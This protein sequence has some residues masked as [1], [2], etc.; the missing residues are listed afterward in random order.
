MKKGSM[1][2]AGLLLGALLP[3]ALG[4]VAGAQE[5]SGADGKPRFGKAFGELHYLGGFSPGEKNW[6]LEQNN[7]QRGPVQLITGGRILNI[8]Q[9]IHCV[10]R[11]PTDRNLF[12]S[13]SAWLGTRPDMSALTP[14]EIKYV[15]WQKVEFDVAIADCPKTWGEAV[16]AIDGPEG[17][18]NLEKLKMQEKAAQDQAYEEGVQQA[19]AARSGEPD[20]MKGATQLPPARLAALSAELDRALTDLRK[21]IPKLDDRTFPDEVDAKITPLL[22][23]IARSGMAEAKAIRKGEAG[24][25]Q[26]EAWDAGAARAVVEAVMRLRGMS[27]DVWQRS[28]QVGAIWVRYLG[29]Y[30]KQIA[31]RGFFEPQYLKEM[32]AAVERY[33]IADVPGEAPTVETISSY[34]VMVMRPPESLMYRVI[35]SGVRNVMGMVMAREAMKRELEQMHQQFKTT[36]AKFWACYKTRCADS[37]PLW[38]DY[39]KLL[40]K[41]DGFMIYQYY[42]EALYKYMGGDGNAIKLALAIDREVGGG[43]IPGCEQEYD[44]YMGSIGRF[45]V[46][47][48]MFNPKEAQSF[49]QERLASADYLKLQQCRDRM[50][51]V[52][53]PRD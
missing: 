25:R 16:N 38:S 11:H 40:G 50:E 8:G 34:R 33:R 43:I 4:G 29:E 7:V 36:R 46:K 17:W 27:G 23:E 42:T 20:W 48:S 53:R 32:I 37:G 26:F 2:G 44:K 1:L 41:K 28:T 24:R 12:R 21:S 10:Y 6:A 22:L 47:G 45:I 15:G 52:L 35:D 51:F 14:A 49:I 5:A 3:L 30:E 19:E 13:I 39:A 31:R 18:A 9:R